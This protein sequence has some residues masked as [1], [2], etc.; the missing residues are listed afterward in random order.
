LSAAH[1]AILRL[2]Y[3]GSVRTGFLNGTELS[4]RSDLLICSDFLIR[5]YRL[6][7][8]EPPAEFR[9]QRL[10]PLVGLQHLLGVFLTFCHEARTTIGGRFHVDGARLD[11]KR[12]RLP[13]VVI[14]R[15]LDHPLLCL[16]QQRVVGRVQDQMDPIGGQFSSNGM[17]SNHPR[18]AT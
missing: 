10:H 3:G 18:D 12:N 8:I 6:Y 5:I 11:E 16:A 4:I 14:Q 1:P 13:V 15:P 2:D 7:V 17:F 9:E